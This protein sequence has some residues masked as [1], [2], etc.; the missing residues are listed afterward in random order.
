[1][2]RR[3]SKVVFLVLM[4]TVL[5]TT[6]CGSSRAD[7]ANEIRSVLGQDKRMS[8]KAGFI[9][10]LFGLSQARVDNYI[11]G[12]KRLDLS[13]CPPGFQSAY[14]EHIRAWERYKTAK[15]AGYN[16]AADAAIK[17]VQQTW[18]RVD[19]EARNFGVHDA[20]SE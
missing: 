18:L 4:T 20:I 16:D 9:E 17:D 11:D 13:R 15:H 10:S 5:A 6:G 2:L 1:M 7:Y 3:F 12:L 14:Q 19:S 8:P